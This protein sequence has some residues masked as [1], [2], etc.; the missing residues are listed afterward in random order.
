[1]S[2]LPGIEQAHMW[3]TF[4]II[5][6]AVILF[7]IERIPLELS[8]G[9]T[10]LALLALFHFFPLNVT[11]GPTPVNITTLLAGFANPV[12]FTILALLMVGQ[13]LIQTGTIEKSTEIFRGLIKIAPAAALPTILVIAALLSAFLNNTPVVILFIPILSA[14]AARLGKTAAH[15]LMPLSFIAILGGMTTLI[16]SSANLVAATVAEANDIPTI[17]FFDFTVPGLLLAG[18][19]ALYVIFVIPRLIKPSPVLGQTDGERGKHFIAQITLN[20]GHPW[21]GIK[22]VAGLFP[23]LH[24]M[25]VKLVQREGRSVLPPFEDLTLQRGDVLMIAAT[26]RN[27]ME[28]IARDRSVIGD[29]AQAEEHPDDAE[30]VQGGERER[31][32]MTEVVIAPGSPR[33]G[34][35]LRPERF[36]FDTGCTLLGIER[37]SR[38]MHDPF[39]KIRLIAGDVLLLLGTPQAVRNLRDHRDLL[40]LARSRAELPVPHHAK[41]A[42]IV[43]TAMILGAASGFVPI[44]IAAISGAIG[45]VLVGALTVPQAA[46]AFDGRIFLLIGAAFA[47]AVALEATGG[48]EFLARKV[49]SIFSGHGPVVLLSA[50]FLLVAILTNFLSNHATGA[51][52]A[53][54]VVSAANQIG[55]DPMPFVYGLIFALNCSFATPIAYQTNLIVMGPGHYRFRDFMIAGLPLIVLI[56]LAYSFFAPLY[57]SM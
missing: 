25:T 53:P 20:E 21:I 10:V 23:G 5:L 28:A 45:M 56:W 11:A 31:L 14:L 6:A 2:L 26:R 29:L 46:R 43:F 35:A 40:L 13:A 41:S 39:H 4:A 12:V 18:I 55:A 54:I 38:M 17:N 47:M 49:V 3:V 36:R 1:M 27:L 32:I 33:I 15:V 50:L 16:G 48:A 22:S 34:R 42:M 52:F 44:S 24:Q 37:H 19:G 7:A 57:F 51:L 8:A 9:L 30:P